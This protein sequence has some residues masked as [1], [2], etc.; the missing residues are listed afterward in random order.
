LLDIAAKLNVFNINLNNV[1]R[2]H[3][4][5]LS[6]QRHHNAQNKCNRWVKNIIAD[7]Q[8]ISPCRTIFDEAYVQAKLRD[9]GYEIKCDGL[10]IFPKNSEE[11][12]KLI[13]TA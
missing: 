4:S 2:T 6:K 1:I 13:F 9:N 10:D 12:H 5:F 3:S 8:S 7:N 11:M